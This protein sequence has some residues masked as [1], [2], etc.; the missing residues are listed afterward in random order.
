MNKIKHAWPTAKL[1]AQFGFAVG[2]V[3]LLVSWF[4]GERYLI[5][6]VEIGLSFIGAGAV[7]AVVILLGAP[8][9]LDEDNRGPGRRS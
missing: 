7:A 5:T 9:V 4:C 2:A 8:L 6:G 3:L 1:V